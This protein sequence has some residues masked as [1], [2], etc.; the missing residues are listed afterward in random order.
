MLGGGMPIQDRAGALRAL[1]QE[2]LGQETDGSHPLPPPSPRPS[3]AKEGGGEAGVALNENR[4]PDGKF[5][6]KGTGDR[7][8]QGGDDHGGAASTGDKGSQDAGASASG[9]RGA[10]SHIGRMA[11]EV[12]EALKREGLEVVKEDRSF[13]SESRYLK[14]EKDGIVHSMRI[15]DHLQPV[16]GGGGMNQT[17]YVS[18]EQR[19]PSGALVRVSKF[20]DQTTLDWFGSHVDMEALGRA[21]P[22]LGGSKRSVVNALHGLPDDYE[23]SR[24]EPVSLPVPEGLERTKDGTVR[25]V[26]VSHDDKDAT[27]QRFTYGDAEATVHEDPSRPGRWLVTV[28]GRTERAGSY[29]SAKGKAVGALRAAAE[30]DVESFLQREKDAQPSTAYGWEIAASRE[31]AGPR[32]RRARDAWKLEH[33]DYEA[34]PAEFARHAKPDG[35]TMNK[36]GELTPEASARIGALLG[37]K[38]VPRTIV[39]DASHAVHVL[40]KHAMDGRPVSPEDFRQVADVVNHADQERLGKQDW[41]GRPTALFARRMEDDTVWVATVALDQ[42]DQRAEDQLRVLSIYKTKGPGVELSEALCSGDRSTW[43]DHTPETPGLKDDSTTGS[44]G[45]SL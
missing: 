18:P 38:N 14:F 29:A 32:R 26:I 16:S 24:P 21:L 35:R 43:P 6:P 13:Q 30:P 4:T 7:T 15:S 20:G 31:A 19:L 1:I 42:N 27:T 23:Y 36:L 2:K 45:M 22:Y 44:G 10:G 39:I 40:Q 28:S 11:G 41:R 17:T 37:V 5:A 12:A 8:G 33:P 34:D 25:A 3:G 9:T